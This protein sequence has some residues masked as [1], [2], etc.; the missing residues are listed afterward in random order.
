MFKSK[1]KRF[2]FCSLFPNKTPIL[3]DLSQP[4]SRP[5]SLLKSD[6]LNHLKKPGPFLDREPLFTMQNFLL[7]VLQCALVL[8]HQTLGLVVR[9]TAMATNMTLEIEVPDGFP[10]PESLGLTLEQLSNPNLYAKEFKALMGERD[11]QKRYDPFCWAVVDG[12]LVQPTAA[13]TCINYLYSLGTQQCSVP[14]APNEWIVSFCRTSYGAGGWSGVEGRNEPRRQPVSSWCQHVAQG[15]VWVM[16]NCA[17]PPNPYF[18]QSGSAAA[19][20]NGD[21][22]VLVTGKV[23]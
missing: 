16:S 5:T 11:L 7:H 14:S 22:A 13:W 3:F 8:S 20:G 4:H 21:L 12:N 23:G 15:A 19:Y 9:Q 1:Y 6:N 10:T 2:Q 18:F 17:Y